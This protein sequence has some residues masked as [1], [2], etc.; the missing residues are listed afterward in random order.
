LGW[1]RLEKRLLR[2]GIIRDDGDEDTEDLGMLDNLLQELDRKR[3]D[4]L[5]LQQTDQLVYTMLKSAQ[6][7]ISSNLYHQYLYLKSLISKDSEL[8]SD[9]LET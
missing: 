3:G 5:L 4:A 6:L 2:A 8:L 7:S 9:Y 1:Q